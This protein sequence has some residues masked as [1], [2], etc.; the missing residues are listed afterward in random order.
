MPG[1]AARFVSHPSPMLTARPGMM[2]L[3]SRRSACRWRPARARRARWRR[4]RP[5]APSA[6]RAPVHDD[7]AVHAQAR[8]AAVGK[9]L[10][11]T[12]V[13]GRSSPTAMK[14][15]AS[16]R[17]GVGGRIGVHGAPSRRATAFVT[18]RAGVER[19]D[20]A[21]RG[22]VAREERGV[23]VHAADPPA[24]PE[25]DDAPVVARRAAPPRLPPVHPLAAR[26]VLAGDENS[27]RGL[28]EIVLRCEE[29]VARRDGT[30]AD[31]GRR[32]VGE[33]GEERGVMIGGHW[34][35]PL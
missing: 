17:S 7:V 18:G 31:A 5:G 9:M 16:P 35:G 11:R 34:R 1:P 20:R 4:D 10:S 24:H 32:E 13:H 12:C 22:I 30:P 8:D 27:R 25:L 33:V 23:H 3:S 15:S 21:R 2:M 6:R 29:I 28:D 26:C 14:L 19:V